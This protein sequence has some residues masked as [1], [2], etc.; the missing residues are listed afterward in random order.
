M[1]KCK[2]PDLIMVGISGPACRCHR[3]DIFDYMQIKKTILS[4]FANSGQ[5]STMAA[6]ILPQNNRIASF[7]TNKAGRCV[8]QCFRNIMVVVLYCN[9][10][11][12]FYQH[13]D[14][15][16]SLNIRQ[17]T[18]HNHKLLFNLCIYV[19]DYANYM[20]NLCSV[21]RLITAERAARQSELHLELLKFMPRG[22]EICV[23]K[24]IN[25]E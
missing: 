7:L 3:K 10:C 5:V 21:E 1:C 13:T 15:I 16:S 8:D 17:I 20:N 18:K 22:T 14:C 19:C 9:N 23:I 12:E 24:Y 11:H 4:D 2:I 6:S 25:W